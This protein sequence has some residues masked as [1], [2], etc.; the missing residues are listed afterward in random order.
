MLISVFMVGT[1][2]QSLEALIRLHNRRQEL[3]E[4]IEQLE[5]PATNVGRRATSLRNAHRLSLG[6][7]LGYDSRN[8][9]LD[10][11]EL[12]PEEVST[13]TAAD[14]SVRVC[15]LCVSGRP[16][17]RGQTGGPS[18]VYASARTVAAPAS[19]PSGAGTTATPHTQ[20]AR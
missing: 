7:P 4:V 14:M 3:Q 19:A 16:E 5:T 13:A 10:Q 1:K 18:R 11:D 2:I 6:V 17:R 12:A 8:L 15:L 9:H 20:Q